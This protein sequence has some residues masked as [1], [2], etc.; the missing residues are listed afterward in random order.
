MRHHVLAIRLDDD[1]WDQ[2]TDMARA[3]SLPTSSYV[4]S[5]ILTQQPPKPRATGVTVEA[6]AALNRLGSLLNQIAKV[7]NSSKTFSATDVR[8]ATAARERILE[9][10]TKLTGD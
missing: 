1:E 8:D 3:V 4:R 7:G 6:V 2:I 5:F 9:I 10:A